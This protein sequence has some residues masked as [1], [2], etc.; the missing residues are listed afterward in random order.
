MGMLLNVAAAMELDEVDQEW[1]R[2]C[3]KVPPSWLEGPPGPTAEA[4]TA[5]APLPKAAA[6]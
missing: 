5:E 6:V 3:S 1:A 2:L 4:P